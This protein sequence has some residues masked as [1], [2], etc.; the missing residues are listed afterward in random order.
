MAFRQVFFSREKRGADAQ[1]DARRALG[2]LQSA[3]TEA[4]MAGLGDATMLPQEMDPIP[5][6][7]VDRAFGAAFA[8]QVGQLAPGQWAGVTAH[9]SPPPREGSIRSPRAPSRTGTAA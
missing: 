9:T 1:A 5:L 8:E 7:E 2:K 3:G 6:P 4:P